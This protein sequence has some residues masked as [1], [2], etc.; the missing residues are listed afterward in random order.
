MPSRAAARYHRPRDLHIDG[1]RAVWGFQLSL[2]LLLFWLLH[3][4]PLVDQSR[5]LPNF[6]FI[7]VSAAAIVGLVVAGVI[8]HAAR[9]HRDAR[10]FLVALALLSISGIFLMHALSTE[11]RLLSQGQAGFIW[12]PALC[13]AL[14]GVFFLLSSFRFN[15]RWNEWLIVNQSRLLVVHVSVIAGY[16]ALLL[17]N[18]SLLIDGLGMTS[19]KAG[20]Y[21]ITGEGGEADTIL[22]GLFVATVCCYG[23][24][25]VR[26]YLENRRRSSVLMLSLIAGATLFGEA[27]AIM[28]F[29]DAW[30][31]SW[32]LY[33]LAM[34]LGF[35]MVGY[36]LLVQFSKRGS[37]HGLFEEV[38][39]REQLTRLDQEYS[40]VI[41]ALINTLEAKDRY[42]QGHSARVAQYSVMLAREMGC[43]EAEVH[44]IE[45]AALLHDLGKLAMPDA[46]LNKPG[47]LT[48]QEFSI[49]QN[50]PVRGCAIIQAVETLQDKIP[51]ILHHH[52]WFNGTGYPSQLAGDD[53]PIDAR[54]IAVADVFDAITSMRAYHLP[55]SRQEAVD[56]ILREAGSHLDPVCVQKFVAGLRKHPI[57][58]SDYTPQV[59]VDELIA[60]YEA[61]ALG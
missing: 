7:V 25:A 21:A 1:R 5:R 3:S 60:R 59:P 39:L 57:Q 47:K 30:R 37:I 22:I 40:G 10:V 4:D 29:S 20:G 46:I 6:H 17:L 50:H 24:A 34:L 49:I 13:L 44:R 14:G 51:G 36:G 28:S 56:H 32:W 48:A 55:V 41:V 2:P 35:V 43:S 26:F 27:D 8:A 16:A 18:P 23:V 54:I 53:I 42:T 12:S 9:S 38:F 15:D 45:Q 58:F 31:L 52:E 19:T 11:N 33:H 61:A